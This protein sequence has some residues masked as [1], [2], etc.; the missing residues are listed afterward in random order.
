MTDHDG[1]ECGCSQSAP[2][3]SRRALLKRATALGV[4]ATVASQGLA[5]KYAFATDTYHGDVV[6]VLSLRGGFDGLN[7][8]VPISDPHYKALRPNVAIP[9]SRLLP[10][11]ENFGMHP[12]LEPLHKY[13]RNGSLGI[14]NAVGFGYRK[15]LVFG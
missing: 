1:S 5:T 4:G 15:S 12:A 2:P 8:F 9:E 13:W 11:N 10:L 6:V 3:L 14:V 7:A